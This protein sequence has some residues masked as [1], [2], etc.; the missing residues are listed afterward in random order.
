MSTIM[1]LIFIGTSG[2]LLG[3]T[4]GYLVSALLVKKYDR[5]KG[6]FLRTAGLICGILSIAFAIGAFTVFSTLNADDPVRGTVV[7]MIVGPLTVAIV[8]SGVI[9][10]RH[11]KMVAPTN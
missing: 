1:L 9:I 10:L 4:I 3:T 11:K 5:E 8:Y 7:P 6:R 2:G